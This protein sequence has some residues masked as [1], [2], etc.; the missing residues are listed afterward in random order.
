MSLALSALLVLVA[1]ADEDSF[2]GG[3]ERAV[4]AQERDEAGNEKAAMRRRLAEDKVR[5]QFLRKE[6]ASI[7]SSIQA[8]DRALEIERK[9][10]AELL[11]KRAAIEAELAKVEQELKESEKKLLPLRDQVGRRAAAMLR[12][13]R[14][15]LAE[16]LAR[17]KSALELR[18]MR[19]RLKLILAYDQKLVEKTKAVSNEARGLKTSLEEEQRGLEATG[20]ELEE[21]KDRTLE[22]REERAALLRAVQSERKM[23]ER[24][25]TEIA[26]AEKKLDTELGAIRGNRPAPDPAPGGFAAQK[27]R[28]PWP[29]AGKVEVPFG[30]R[31]DP[32]TGMVMAHKG[33]DVRAPI[34]TPVRAVFAGRV[35]HKGT[36]DGYG[37]VVVLEH[38]GGYFSIYAHL[39]SFA[40][41][42]EVQQ[43][44]VIGYV[45]DSGSVKGPYL[46]LELRE[47][48]KPID[49]LS[50]LAK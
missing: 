27:G 32:A 22:L 47:G 42:D 39:E 34:T 5:S 31:V 28:L 7:F 37:R 9:K 45:G 16:I 41:G 38:E 30:K 3:F 4:E 35:A 46:Y 40:G 19:D 1:Q 24:L 11:K 44:E 25:A 50:W 26:Q 2:G 21:E 33:I 14:T 17:A 8:L 18:R 15:A 36:L 43:G 23:I 13:R 29:L 48:R 49:P 6:E 20:K 12:L 10:G